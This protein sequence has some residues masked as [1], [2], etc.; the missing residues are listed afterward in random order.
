MLKLERGWQVGEIDQVTWHQ[1]YA[2][3]PRFGV[4]MLKLERGW[5]VGE[6]CQVT[7]H[8]KYAEQPRFGVEM[9]KLESSSLM[10]E[11][12]QSTWHQNY[13]DQQCEMMLG[14]IHMLLEV[15]IS[16]VSRHGNQLVASGIVEKPGFKLLIV[17]RA[18][19]NF[20]VSRKPGLEP[21]SVRIGS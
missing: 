14:L 8:Q 10:G 12:G 11:M 7:W 6:I 18:S 3:Q 17:V 2:E 19:E 13:E 21:K 20:V 15:K 4:E 9:L 1:K 16:E 5:Q